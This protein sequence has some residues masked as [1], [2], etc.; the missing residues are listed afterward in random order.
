MFEQEGEKRIREVVE[1][2]LANKEVAGVN[3]L[4]MKQG[5]ELFYYDGGMRNIEQNVKMTRDTLFRLYSMTKPVTAIGAMILLERGCID[6]YDSVSKYLPGFKNQHVDDGIR[7]ESVQREV[8]LQDLLSM[9]SGLVYP[10]GNS[11]AEQ[12]MAEAFQDINQ[13]FLD[14]HPLTTYEIA[15][16]IGQLPLAFQPGTS[17]LYGTSADILGAVIEQVS[18]QS[19]GEFF[20]TE[21]FSRLGMVDT[22]FWV[23]EEKRSRLATTYET[24]DDKTLDLYEGNNLGIIHK[25]DCK[26][27]FESGGAG[28]ASTI[29]D[30]A[31]IGEMLI[32]GGVYQEE[33]ILEPRTVA[34]LT[35]SILHPMQQKAFD[36]WHGL[37]GH[38]YG[39]FMRVMTESRQAGIIGSEGEY[40]WDG[41]LGGYF[42]NSPK[43]KITIL[44]MMQK[45]DAGTIGM[46]R[47]I[48]NIVHSFLG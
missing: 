20:D 29:D 3:L 22:G 13:C 36:Q 34:Y 28:L 45:K 39:N 4:V 30:Y 40:G 9:T 41:W 23:P 1:Q 6:L 7:C 2:G 38:S 5:K 35:S 18:G 43:E 25:M 10:G 15:N 48:R 17:W 33:K 24:K 42:S 47:K 16:R 37:S 44:V 27:T 26:P 46:T 19:L 14:N 21:I 32:N 31:K 11:K 12:K 8:T